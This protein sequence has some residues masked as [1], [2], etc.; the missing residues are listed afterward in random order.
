MAQKGGGGPDPLDPPLDPPLLVGVCVTCRT[1]RNALQREPM[2]PHDVPVGLDLFSYKGKDYLLIVDY[3][4]R[5]FEVVKLPDM[6]A[7]TIVTNTKSIFSRHGIPE[8]VMSDNGPQYTSSEY[9][10]F[11]EA[12]EFS[13]ET[14]SPRYP[15][16]NGLAERTVQTVK[17]ILTKA[18]ESNRD[19]YLAILEYR[20]TQIDDI[21]SPAQLLMSRRLRSII[22]T[23]TRQLKPMIVPAQHAWNKLQCK[24]NKQTHYYDTRAKASSTHNLQSGDKVFIKVKPDGQWRPGIINSH[25]GTP[26][27]Y[28]V[29]LPDGGQY[30]RN[31]KQH[32][33]TTPATKQPPAECDKLGQTPTAHKAPSVDTDDQGLITQTPVQPEPTAT[34]A[35]TPACQT[36]RSGRIRRPPE[37]LEL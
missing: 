32:I 8:V 12:W 18:E 21:A 3:Y 36:S 26:R 31:N 7:A 23:T 27:S 16:S 9:K 29:S 24:Q 19:P 1:H 22:P 37:R 35:S 5:F 20:N 17:N 25:A 2:Q 30:R 11:S 4:S 33:M 13:H 15:Q 14:S 28:H 34:P 6:R 10:S